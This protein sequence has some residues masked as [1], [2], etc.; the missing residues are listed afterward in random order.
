MWHLI[1]SP[2][3]WKALSQ[4]C[5]SPQTC[6]SSW[7]MCLQAKAPSVWGYAPGVCCAWPQL[8]RSSR[9]SHGCCERVG[10]SGGVSVWTGPEDMGLCITFRL[11]QHSLL[12]LSQTQSN[13]RNHT[14]T[15]NS[16]YLTHTHNLLRSQQ[17]WLQINRMVGSCAERQCR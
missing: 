12:N 1:P 3:L 17:Q 7:G 8:L 11:V 5:A 2:H 14:R 10:F 15:L 6:F 16:Q 4:P 9:Q 13:W